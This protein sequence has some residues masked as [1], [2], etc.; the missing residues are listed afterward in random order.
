MPVIPRPSVT[1]IF[2]HSR[3]LARIFTGHHTCLYATGSVQAAM[4][5]QH[6]GQ[7]ILTGLLLV[8]ATASGRSQAQA[9]EPRVI[10]VVAKRFVFEPSEIEVTVGERVRLAVR[11]ADGVHGIEI[12]KVKVSKEIPRGAAPVIIEFTADAR[13]G[14]SRSSAPSTAE[15]VMTT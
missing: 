3:Q 9:P 6:S 14:V 12:K 8:A 7:L 5:R 10:E 2:G 1:A 13:L 4:I 11:S 15:T